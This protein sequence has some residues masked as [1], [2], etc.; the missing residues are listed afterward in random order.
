MST[1]RY[2]NETLNCRSFQQSKAKTGVASLKKRIRSKEEKINEYEKEVKEY[3]KTR[4]RP[5]KAKKYDTTA[6]SSDDS[7]DDVHVR[8]YCTYFCI[9]GRK[10]VI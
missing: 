3:E 2:A 7:D 1:L 5:V 10:N 4:K 8:I 6:T 9:N